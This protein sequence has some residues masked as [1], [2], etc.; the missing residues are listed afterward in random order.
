MMV[1]TWAIAAGSLLLIVLLFLAGRSDPVAERMDGLSERAGGAEVDHL[2]VRDLRDASPTTTDRRYDGESPHPHVRAQAD[3]ELRE[4]LVQAGVYRDRASS[5]FTPVRV[6]SFL[7]P[8]LAGIG[9]AISGACSPAIAILLGASVGGMGTLA[10]SFWL[11]Y[12][13]RKRQTLIRRS[14]PDA[15][16]TVVV[17]L[18]GGLSLTASFGRVANE[19]SAAHPLLAKELKIVDREVQMGRSMGE[20]MRNF[21][22][23]FDLEELRGMS[24]VIIHAE[25]YGAS[26]SKAMAT[27]AD[28]LRL[29]RQQ[30]AEE[31]A[32][33]AAVKIL[34]PTLLCIFPAVFIVVLGPAAIQ[35]V[36]VL[37]PA[38]PGG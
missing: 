38:L 4:R 7:I 26:V 2:R 3:P 8:V 33:K 21:A 19:L 24:S 6:V 22:W 36:R 13:K 5:W 9:L 17:C 11:D 12:L 20:A 35:I 32:H 30:R 29:K 18:E 16:D 27:Y 25:R 10:P 23:R 34:F 31:M 15:L 37:F 1:L 14:L 28:S